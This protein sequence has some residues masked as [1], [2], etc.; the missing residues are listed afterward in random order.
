MSQKEEEDLVPLNTKIPQ[1]INT[2]IRLAA[3]KLGLKLQPTTKLIYTLGLFINE[4]LDFKGTVDLAKARYPI[5]CLTAARN[6]LA[7][8]KYPPTI[9]NKIDAIITEV[10]EIIEQR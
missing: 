7:Q 1:S 10:E 9:L 2:R 4:S 8:Q 3:V 5:V 6:D